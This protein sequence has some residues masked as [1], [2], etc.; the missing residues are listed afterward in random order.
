M[1][2]VALNAKRQEQIDLSIHEVER[3]RQDANDGN[4][5]SFDGKAAA[6]HRA[7]S[8]K[9]GLPITVG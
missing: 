3:C 4:L 6:Q 2:G 1:H 5:V 9:M 8:T 7:V